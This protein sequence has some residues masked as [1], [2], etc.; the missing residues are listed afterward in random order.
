[1][2]LKTLTV[3]K[4]MPIKQ[5]SYTLKVDKLTDYFDVDDGQREVPVNMT[6]TAE[7]FLA[8]D[9]GIDELS[10]AFGAEVLWLKV[11]KQKNG[12]KHLIFSSGTKVYFWHFTKQK[13]YPLPTSQTAI[14]GTVSVTQGSTT[15]TGSGTDFVT[16]LV[17]GQIVVING[18]YC[19]VTVINNG[20]NMTVD[21]AI[22][23]A[24]GT[25]LTL[26]K[27]T[28]ATYTAGGL[29]GDVE[30]DDELFFGNA[31]DDYSKFDGVL[32]TKY[33]TLP[34]GNVFEVFEDRIFVS[35]V[36]AE[37]LSFYY[38]DVGAPTT[39]DPASVIKPLGTDFITGLENY[40]GTLIIFKSNSIWKMTFVY[41]QVASDFLPKL[42]LMNKNYGCAGFR[43]YT[44]V[45][46]DIWFF[47]GLEVRALGFRDQQ[48]GVLG[49][50]PSVISN[51][52]KET[53]KNITNK[54]SSVVFYYQRQFYLAVSLLGFNDVVFVSHLL[55][56][57]A[58]TKIK[59]RKK[60]NVRCF[61]VDVDTS[62]VFFSSSL[63]NRIFEWNDEYNDA[64]DAISCYVNFKE[65]EDKDFSQTN[66]FR[67]T[68]LKFKNL[69]T[70]VKVNVWTDDFDARSG[71]SK[72]FFV[73]TD[74]EG[75]DNALG[76]V[77]VGEHLIADAFGEEVV[78]S[79]FIKRRISHLV[80]GTVYQ[81]G[82]ANDILN[83]SFTIAGFEITG[84]R[85]PRRYYSHSKVISI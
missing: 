59:D 6:L 73:G 47:T 8:K 71:R 77:T 57:N 65:Y 78:A 31:I 3:G 30:Y 29:F 36:V 9:F 33:N 72:E 83:D 39:F 54:E 40:Y 53:L 46:N 74:I 23:Q 45:E 42:E 67:Y 68:D 12:T 34:K 13:G 15:V 38:S 84:H 18:E 7:G 10:E 11:F 17:V 28:D 81:L 63:E 62:E 52:I 61:A 4:N 51:P 37:P 19:E 76:E 24:N 25:G 5:N 55:Y 27:N 1:M 75:E 14:S 22:E 80:R 48:T 43:A 49:L 16:D 44:W 58:W 20:T 26:N 60:A 50:D 82:L 56:K 32:I 35:G 85:R 64:G 41:D 69:Q 2:V 21:K 66:V 79:N 70:I